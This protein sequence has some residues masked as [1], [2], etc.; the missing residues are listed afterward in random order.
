[1]RVACSPLASTLEGSRRQFC[2]TQAASMVEAESPLSNSQFRVT[3]HEE[4]MVITMNRPHARHAA[5]L[6][7]MAQLAAARIAL[8]KDR[9]RSEGRLERWQ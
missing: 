5:G 6:K 9:N 3:Q 1:M 4:A 7:M 8:H 2:C